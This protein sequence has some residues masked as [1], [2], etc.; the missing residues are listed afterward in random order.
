[1]KPLTSLLV[2]IWLWIPCLAQSPDWNVAEQ[3]FEHTMSLVAFLNLDGRTLEGL[4]NKVAAFVDGECRGVSSLTEVKSH[5]EH[6]AYLTL[7]GHSNNEVM[8]FKIY[9]ATNNQVVDVDQPLVFRINSHRG[10]LLQPYS[11]AQPTLRASASITEV[12][13]SGIPPLEKSNENATIVFRVDHSTSLGPHT[14]LFEP[15]EGAQVFWNNQPLASGD[16]QLDFSQPITIQVR[17]EDRSLLRSWTIVIERM[18]DL[19]VYKRNLSCL[20][21]GAIKI[22]GN[23]DG[24]SFSLVR[25]G[26]VISTRPMVNGEVL[27]E[28]LFQGEYIVRSDA[29]EK[30]VF[31]E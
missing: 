20:E 28:S 5:Q 10:N 4:G 2:T 7:F 15:V 9:D 24:Q 21:A 12:T 13:L 30:Q 17:S 6:L 1:M 19:L 27:F 29:F 14:L 11:I 22:T 31:I 3:D 23:R 18:G 8:T 16:N 26:Q 25:A